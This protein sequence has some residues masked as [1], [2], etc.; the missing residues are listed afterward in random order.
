MLEPAMVV[1]RGKMRDLAGAQSD[2]PVRASLQQARMLLQMHGMKL[3]RFGERVSTGSGIGQL[4][5]DL[6]RAINDRHDL[7]MLGGGNPAHIPAVEACL[8]EYMLEMLD[9]GRRFEQVIGNYDPPQGNRAFIEA[10]ASLL[11]RQFGWDVGPENI[12]IT[13][14]SQSAFFI[15]FNIFAGRFSDGTFRKILLPLT[16]EYIGYADLGLGDDLFVATRPQIEHIDG[17]IFKYHV[18]F[19]AIEVTD[20]TGAICISRPTNPTANVLSDAELRKLSRLAQDNDIP[21][22]IDSAYGAPFPGIIFTEAEPFWN[23]NVIVCMSLSKLGLPAART[24]IV[25]ANKEVISLISKVNAIVS[26]A[27]GGLGAALATRMV[28]D[29]RIIELSRQVIRPYYQKKATEALQQVLDLFDGTDFYVHKPEGA[30]FLWL[31]FKDLPISDQQL[32]DR[33]KQQAVVVVP[34]RHFFPGFRQKWRHKQECIRVSY[35]QDARVVSRGLRVI[36]Q[37]VKQAYQDG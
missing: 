1:A 34:G 18:D 20:D 2:R 33:L 21:L 4:M 36:A 26:L 12:A 9:D 37:Q 14:G 19:D 13:N 32:Y 10:T 23:E 17:R 30:F 31:W 24:G 3:S 5:E 28:S 35:A 27:P 11:Q 22:I 29:G 8:R 25:V 6:G 7:L 16:P 15:L